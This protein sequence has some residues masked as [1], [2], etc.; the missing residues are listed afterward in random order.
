MEEES[1]D[2]LLCECSFDR[3]IWEWIFRWCGILVPHFDKNKT[4]WNSGKRETKK[5]FNQTRI[6]P[7]NVAGIIKST[8][9]FG[10]NIGAM[11]M[12]V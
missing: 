9:S 4:I 2:Y 6:T 12:W 8:S 3:V 10:S 7:T 5:T 11:G 1:T